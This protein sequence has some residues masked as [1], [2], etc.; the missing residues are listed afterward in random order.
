MNETIKKENHVISDYRCFFCFVKAFERILDK[1]DLPPEGKKQ[2]AGDMFGLFN[3][4][5][6]N[7]SVPTLSRELHVLLK[8]YS[9]NPDPYKEAMQ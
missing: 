8:Q 4:V 1:E 3:K 5:K 7:F 6:N 2:F 9:N